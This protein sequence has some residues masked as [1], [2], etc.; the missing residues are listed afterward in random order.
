MIDFQKLLSEVH[1]EPYR[2]E[3]V[4]KGN[5]HFL[6]ARYDEADVLNGEPSVQTTRKWYLSPFMT[7]S[8]FVQTCLKC[9]LTSMEHRARE[10]FEYKGKR[11]FG[12]HYDV[13]ALHS[14]CDKTDVRE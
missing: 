7:K 10:A 5:D 1:C 12:P 3:I 6:L 8:E 14:V 11:I 13:D 4:T 2:F 9:V